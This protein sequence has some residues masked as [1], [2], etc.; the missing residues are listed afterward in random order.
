MLI[1]SFFFSAVVTAVFSSSISFICFDQFESKHT[2]VMQA[3]KQSHKL[4]IIDSS[5]TH[6]RDLQEAIWMDLYIL[7]LDVEYM[8]VMYTYIIYIF[9][10]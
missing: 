7:F 9:V 10:V 4:N 2:C 3:G 1:E 5:Q 6:S 8:Y